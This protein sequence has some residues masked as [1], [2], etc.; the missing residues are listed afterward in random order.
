MAK[1]SKTIGASGSW[2]DAMAT[3]MEL[4]LD[5]NEVAVLH[6]VVENY[7]SEVRHA[8]SRGEPQAKGLL[9]EEEEVLER[10]LRD[11]HGLTTR[12]R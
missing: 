8:F 5:A 11:L 3:E 2:S 4:K 1:P 6:R 9:A 12:A 7:L 10:I